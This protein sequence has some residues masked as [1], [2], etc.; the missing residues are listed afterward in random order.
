VSTSPLNQQVG[1]GLMAR[2]R[3]DRLAALL[4]EA[5]WSRAQAATAFN[6]V[7]AESRMA[8][9]IGR[10]H[11]SMWVAGTKPAGDAPLILAEALSRRLMR[12]VT[13]GELGLAAPGGAAPGAADWD[14]DPLAALADLGRADLDAERRG[15]LTGA[16]YSAVLAA[17]PGQDW[18]K[19][20]AAETPL[21]A[22]SRKAGRGDVETVRQ[23]TAAF[24]RMDQQRGG[25]H[26]R[27]AV[28]QYLR[29]DVAPLLQ[30]TFADEDVRR[31]MFSAAAELAYLS[32]WMAFDNSQHATAQRYFTLAVQLAATADDR[33]LT[34]H[35]L[36]AMGPPGDRPRRPQ[37]GT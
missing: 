28:V 21:S 26:G 14:A 36:R 11:V 20:R 16:A 32:G 31:D 22:R 10:S 13:P 8:A 12:L 27:R 3:N 5:G 29:S 17:L 19:G 25:G 15:I 18:W 7:A 24:S 33:P 35:I 37:A 4:Q 23:L 9:G 30:G 6:H 1:F 2:V 34:G